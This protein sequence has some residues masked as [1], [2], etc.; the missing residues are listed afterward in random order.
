MIFVVLT[1]VCT[2][3]FYTNIFWYKFI[4]NGHISLRFVNVFL[5]VYKL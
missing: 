5:I 3:V 1:D 4:R 2:F